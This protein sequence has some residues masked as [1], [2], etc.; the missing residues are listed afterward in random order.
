MTIILRIAV[1]SLNHP[2]E[3]VKAG[4][5]QRLVSVIGWLT[6]INYD[7]KSKQTVLLDRNEYTKKWRWTHIQRH[8]KLNK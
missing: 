8:C 5:D 4:W 7:L 3:W 2:G 6:V 1:Y